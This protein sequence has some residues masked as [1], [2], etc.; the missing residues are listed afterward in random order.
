MLMYAYV[1]RYIL[2]KLKEMK[3]EEAP[4]PEF[5]ACKILRALRHVTVN[6][7][8]TAVFEIHMEQAN[9]DRPLRYKK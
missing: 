1:F 5:E 6:D 3:R 7:E 2:H 9:P 4:A 8:G